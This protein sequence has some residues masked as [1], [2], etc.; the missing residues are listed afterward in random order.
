MRAGTFSASSHRRRINAADTRGA[1]AVVYGYQ[2][3]VRNIFQGVFN[4]VEAGESA[5]HQAL[6]ALETF[7]QAILS[8]GD[9]VRLRQSSDNLDIG[10]GFQEALQREPEDGFSLQFQELLGDRTAHPGSH[11]PR[12]HYQISFSAHAPKSL[13]EYKFFFVILND[14][15]VIDK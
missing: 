10:I 2:N 14:Y 8:P 13:C 4:G 5:F 1:H 12:C 11:A 15:S 3:P 6:P 9:H 7:L